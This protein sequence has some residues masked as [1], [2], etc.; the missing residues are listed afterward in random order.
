MEFCPIRFLSQIYRLLND[1]KVG[2][3]IC[4]GLKD[5]LNIKL[6]EFSRQ[7]LRVDQTCRIFPP[8]IDC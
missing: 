1:T 3:E 8:K 5:L 4:N 2:L 7:K 6:A